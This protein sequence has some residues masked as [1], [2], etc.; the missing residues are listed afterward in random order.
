MAVVTE[1]P[2]LQPTISAIRGKLKG[3]Q[4]SQDRVSLA[5]SGHMTTLSQSVWP[6]DSMLSDWPGLGPGSTKYMDL[7]GDEGGPLKTG[8]LLR[9]RW[10]SSQPRACHHLLFY[11]TLGRGRLGILAAELWTLT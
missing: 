10:A 4:K 7:R 11:V 3:Q 5:G 6:G 9:R 8:L 2:G 1:A